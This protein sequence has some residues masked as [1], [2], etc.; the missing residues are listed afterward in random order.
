MQNVWNLVENRAIFLVYNYI[1]LLLVMLTLAI[2]N[3]MP[4]Q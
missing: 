2:V 4:I 3:Y 1:Q